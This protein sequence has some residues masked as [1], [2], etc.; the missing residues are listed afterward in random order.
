MS[1]AE[2]K[3]N[4]ARKS[5]LPQ[6][7]V[8]N[9][10]MSVGLCALLLFI[11]SGFLIWEDVRFRHDRTLYIKKINQL[12]DLD[13]QRTTS[14]LVRSISDDYH[15]SIQAASSY[16]RQYQ[17]KPEIVLNLSLALGQLKL[18][19]VQVGTSSVN[20][21][22]RLKIQQKIDEINKEAQ[23]KGIILQSELEAESNAPLNEN[24]TAVPKA[25]SAKEK[26]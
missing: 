10:Q 9:E 3:I 26:P 24:A 14:D 22:A 7:V 23:T 6:K 17:R 21:P 5:K 11:C 12:S 18:A 8:W 4:L 2:R 16:L 19:L 15:A 1:L 20:E 13:Q 25:E